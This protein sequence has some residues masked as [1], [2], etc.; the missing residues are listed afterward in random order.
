MGFHRWQRLE[1]KIQQRKK[2]SGW[3][4]Y[5]GWDGRFLDRD[6]GGEINRFR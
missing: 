2:T 3:R 5:E 4:H 1:D 6:R